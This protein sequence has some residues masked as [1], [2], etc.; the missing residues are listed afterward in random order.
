MKNPAILSLLVCTMS[1]ARELF[2]GYHSRKHNRRKTGVG[3]RYRIIFQERSGAIVGDRDN[4]PKARSPKTA[5]V[6]IEV[7]HDQSDRDRRAGCYELSALYVATARAMGLEA[8]GVERS[9]AVG[10]GQIG[11]R[12]AGAHRRDREDGCEEREAEQAQPDEC[13][14]DHF[15]FPRPPPRPSSFRT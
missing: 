13:K 10:T 1:F 2:F 15:G 9:D 3:R 5:A 8:A 12:V 11:Q 14:V 6:L 7:A 4:V